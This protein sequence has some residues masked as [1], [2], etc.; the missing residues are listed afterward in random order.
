VSA[1]LDQPIR[2]PALDNPFNILYE[3]KPT[4]AGL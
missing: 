3:I 2:C 4:V 1:M